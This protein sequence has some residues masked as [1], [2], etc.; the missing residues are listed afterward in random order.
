MTTIHLLNA[1][2]VIVAKIKKFAADA[3]SKGL[4]ES[5]YH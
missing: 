2:K 3:F 1:V 5:V 4:Y